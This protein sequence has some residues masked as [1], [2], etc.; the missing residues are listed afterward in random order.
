MDR[1][2]DITADDFHGQ[3]DDSDGEDKDDF[4]DIVFSQDFEGDTEYSTPTKKQRI[5]DLQNDL[6]DDDLEPNAVRPGDGRSLLDHDD[7]AD[8]IQNNA[9]EVDG[10]ADPYPGAEG[11]LPP[12][13]SLGAHMPRLSP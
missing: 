4:D 2:L 7:E 10:T 8:N 11:S 9:L 12:F 5:Y 1:S 6:T 13:E 3:T